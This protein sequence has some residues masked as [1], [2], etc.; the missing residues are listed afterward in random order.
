MKSKEIS[1]LNA[2]LLILYRF[3]D[4]DLQRFHIRP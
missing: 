2:V 1:E 3:I 4:K